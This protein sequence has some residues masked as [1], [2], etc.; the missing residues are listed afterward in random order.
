MRAIHLIVVHST[1]TPTSYK[2]LPPT[3]GY[4]YII[5][6]SGNC[7]RLQNDAHTVSNISG[8]DSGAIH[9]A[10]VGGMSNDGQ[11]Y[12]NRNQFQE[13]GLFDLLVSLSEKYPAAKIIGHDELETSATGCPGFSVKDWL[14]NYEP[15]IIKN[16]A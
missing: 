3:S 13:D 11:L 10:Y 2:G 15:Q 14:A 1:A 7:R 12:D 4:H 6:R 8:T 9:V 5:E 16:A